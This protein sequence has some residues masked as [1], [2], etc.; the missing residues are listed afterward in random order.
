MKLTVW[1]CRSNVLSYRN[2]QESVGYL[3]FW[4]F[5]QSSSCARRSLVGTNIENIIAHTT[6]YAIRQRR[7]LVRTYFEDKNTL[8]CTPSRHHLPTSIPTLWIAYSE[9]YSPSRP[10]RVMLCLVGTCVV[11]GELGWLIFRSVII[12]RVAIVCSHLY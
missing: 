8:L 1:A 4:C 9:L 5:V 10:A 11:G 6:L 12:L 7:S 3:V 2:L